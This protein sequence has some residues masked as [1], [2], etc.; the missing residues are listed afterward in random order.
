MQTDAFTYL[1]PSPSVWGHDSV[2]SPEQG[3][4]AGK[5]L[6]IQPSLSVRGWPADAGSVAL[7]GFV[8]LE[9][10]TVIERLKKAGATLVGTSRMSELGLG[11][12]GD[13]TGRILSEGRSDMALMT[14][15]MGEARIIAARVGAFAFKPSNGTVSRFGLIGLAP[16][17]ECLGILA[18]APEDIVAV[19]GIM[20]GDD[21][22]DF[23]MCGSEAPRF[24][25]VTES[26]DSI[27]V[28]GFM[29]EPIETLSEAEVRAFRGCLDR[30]EKSGLRIREVSLPDYDLF[31]SVHHCIGAVEASSSC[32]KYDGVR[33]GH[34]TAAAKNW[35]DMYLKTRAESFGALVKA[36][37]FQ[38]AY[39]QFENYGAF[40]NAC[41]IRARLVK[42]I[43]GL[44]AEVDALAFPTRSGS[45]REASAE[46]MEGLYDDFVLTLPANVAGV[47]AVQIPGYCTDGNADYGLQIIGPRLC[48]GPLLSLAVRLSKMGT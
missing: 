21:D 41:R 30:L 45:I 37:L 34:R 38:G 35:N 16:S 25:H 5:S 6:T 32:G 39:F 20:A 13:T 43:N 19:M 31:R 12:A 40:E 3:P 9:D 28:I 4:L 27:K 42:V 24:D 26:D 23:S 8:A 29:K 14:D 18:R 44:F 2:M 15:M 7:K 47:P 1:D 48:D 46:D 36:Y 11:L 17:M 33:Y 22:R 10:A